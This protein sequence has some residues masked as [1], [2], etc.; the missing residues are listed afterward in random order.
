MAT[1]SFIDPAEAEDRNVFCGRCDH[2]VKGHWASCPNCSA[3]F[4]ANMWGYARLCKNSTCQRTEMAGHAHGLCSFH[5]KQRQYRRA[6]TAAQPNCHCGNKLPLGGV[7]CRGCDWKDE[8]AEKELNRI[9][10]RV[11]ERL[12]CHFKSL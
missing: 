5:H 9:A 10:D 2:P 7:Q 8:Q 1:N 3:G 12:S 6:R 4:H 11:A